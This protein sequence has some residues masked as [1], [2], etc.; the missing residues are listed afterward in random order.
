MLLISQ[1]VGAAALIALALRLWN[2]PRVAA[3]VTR[4]ARAPA[5]RWLPVLHRDFEPARLARLADL[6]ARPVAGRKRC[7]LRS[8]LLLWLLHARGEPA[9]L[10][11]GAGRDP[12]R[13]LEG[14]AWIEREGRPLAEVVPPEARFSSFLQLG[15]RP[16]P[17]SGRVATAGDA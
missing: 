17:D 7:L 4:G 13:G 6:A 16:D 10:V 12:E 3:A 5:L 8:L 9:V 2:L 15:A 1:L 11:V 14:H